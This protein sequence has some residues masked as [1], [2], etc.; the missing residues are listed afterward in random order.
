M[1]QA[2]SRDQA[3]SRELSALKPLDESPAID[4]FSSGLPSLD[5][6]LG[7]GFPK[8]R[9]IE[10]FGPQS[11]GKT[12]LALQAAAQCQEHGKVAFLDTEHRLDKAYAAA[13]GVDTKTL[14]FGQ[15]KSAEDT[16][17]LVWDAARAGF[18]LVVIDSITAM[19]TQSEMDSRIEES[20][21]G[22][23]S[24]ALSNGLKRIVQDLGGESQT[25][26]IVT[27]QLR[28]CL[29]VAFGSPERATGGLALGY[30]TSVRLE[31]RRTQTLKRGHDEF[32]QRV[33]I[34]VAKS[35]VANPFQVTESDLIFGEGFSY[36]HDLLD[37][38]GTLGAVSQRARKYWMEGIEIGRDRYE[39]IDFLKS[40]PSHLKQLEESI[41]QCR[42]EKA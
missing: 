40:N 3:I 38:A 11:G 31:L 9:I 16:L 28:Q 17:Q 24:Q 36:V 37:L 1:V 29:G 13:V 27:N 25:T 8:G 10:I 34:K 33:K 18:S 32:G 12:T 23:H 5:M 22:L 15:P 21:P 7:G 41:A 26:L 30:Y 42:K 4:Y 19:P 14:L 2:I 35:S 20:Q 6:I 39:A